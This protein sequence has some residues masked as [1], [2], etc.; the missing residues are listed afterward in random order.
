MA[1]YTV[2]GSDQK[3]YGSVTADN[4]CRWIADGRLNAQSLMRE[5]SDTE[6][7]PLSTFPEF[8]DTFAAKAVTMGVLPTLSTAPP[9]APAKMS[10]MA[11]TSLV[12]GILGMFTCGITALVG[13]ILGI[14]AMV[15]VKNSGGR[16]GGNGIALAGVIVSGIFL[17]MIPIF[18]ALML[19]ALAAAKQR[20]QSINC[21]SN[22]KQLATG[23]RMYSSDN[24]DQLPPA[25]TWCDAIRTY[26]GSEKIFQCP[27]GKSNARC[28]Y[29]FNAKLG[30]MDENKVNPHTV[31]IFE[32]DGGW[33]A[34]GGFELMISKPRHARVFV[35]AFA[36]GSVQELRESQLNTLRW[37]P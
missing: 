15:K 36:D 9:A 31:M 12:L 2:I 37:D 3:Q 7:R 1:T 35:V 21:V 8:A 18:A 5:E 32:S 27:A 6:F 10:G 26:V 4:I 33:N 24:K 14:I 16:L 20:A 28:S 29:A 17:L 25:A 34:N 19:P 23:V 13:L 30:G 22:E 11:V